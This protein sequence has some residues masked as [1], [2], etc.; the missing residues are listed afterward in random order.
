LKSNT[1]WVQ[2]LHEKAHSSVFI[3]M[4]AH[5]NFIAFRVCS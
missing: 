5:D 3:V 2:N 4:K 1:L